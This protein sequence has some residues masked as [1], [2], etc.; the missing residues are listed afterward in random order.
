[1]TDHIYFIHDPEQHRIKIGSTVNLVERLYALQKAVG[2]GL[3]VLGIMDG[4][5]PEEER[6]QQHFAH[7]RIR[8]DRKRGQGPH[9]GQGKEWFR[10]EPELRE[11][12]AA[13]ARLWE[14]FDTFALHR[15]EPTLVMQGTPAWM[16][17]VEQLARNL[18]TSEGSAVDRAL[19]L[20]ASQVGVSPP[21]T[22]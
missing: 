18:G 4:G 5:Q 13:N 6:I 10:D 3:V 7:L 19:A 15:G 11:F 22:R 9:K 2:R 21:P 8:Y 14:K 12:I 16:E 20:L 17:W 1:M